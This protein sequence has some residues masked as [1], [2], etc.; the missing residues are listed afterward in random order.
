MTAID[1]LYSLAWRRLCSLSRITVSHT[2]WKLL[3]GPE[4]V[5]LPTYD[6]SDAKGRGGEHNSLPNFLFTEIVII[7]HI[8][9]HRWRNRFVSYRGCIKTNLQ[10]LYV[11]QQFITCFYFKSALICSYFPWTGFL[12][13]RLLLRLSRVDFPF[14]VNLLFSNSIMKLP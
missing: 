13:F 2:M 11:C 12:I 10:H 6:P 8:F 5:S 1:S 9:S 4:S 7:C 3:R 14:H